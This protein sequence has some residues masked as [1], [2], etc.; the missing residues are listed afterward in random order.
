MKVYAY[1]KDYQWKLQKSF[2]SA[3]QGESDAGEL[4]QS[5]TKVTLYVKVSL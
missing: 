5:E 3:P 1:W 2:G 4:R